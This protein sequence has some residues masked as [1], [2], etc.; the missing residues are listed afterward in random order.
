MKPKSKKQK[1]CPDCKGTRIE[2]GSQ[3][4]ADAG[5]ECLTC[6][7]PMRISG[8]CAKL[9]EAKA[10]LRV[11]QKYSTFPDADSFGMKPI[12]ELCD[13]TLEAIK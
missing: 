3:N 12:R 6:A 10:A 4:A 9:E 8:T 5:N 13:K 11:I 2:P 1:V 7:P